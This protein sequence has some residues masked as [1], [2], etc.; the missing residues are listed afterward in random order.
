MT[1]QWRH[2]HKTH[3]WYSKLNPLQNIYFDILKF[4]KLTELCHF[5]TYLRNDPRLS[6]F[7]F[8]YVCLEHCD[9]SGDFFDVCG[10]TSVTVTRIPLVILL[11]FVCFSKR[12]HR[13]RKSPTVSRDVP[14]AWH[15][16][17]TAAGPA[18]A[19]G[20]DLA[21]ELSSSRDDAASLFQTCAIDLTLIGDGTGRESIEIAATEALFCAYNRGV[22]LRYLY[23]F[24]SQPFRDTVSQKTVHFCFCQN[25]ASNCNR[26]CL[27]SFKVNGR[28]DSLIG[29]V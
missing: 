11:L 26:K 14:F 27:R 2:R 16:A 20:T 5:V 10:I 8:L 28:K 22:S 18:K 13:S 23:S 12:P 29:S 3:S 15:E 6:V 7:C 25:F 19:D 1:S 24:A 21:V 4:W 17:L 9:I